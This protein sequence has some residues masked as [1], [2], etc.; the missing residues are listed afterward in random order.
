MLIEINFIIY[1][2]NYLEKKKRTMDTEL[3]YHS[4]FYFG[5]L[6]HNWAE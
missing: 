1:K 3:A 6:F 2:K 4:E 5:V